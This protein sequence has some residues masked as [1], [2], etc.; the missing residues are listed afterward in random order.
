[1]PKPKPLVDSFMAGLMKDAKNAVD[2]VTKQADIPGTIIPLTPSKKDQDRNNIISG[3]EQEQINIIIEQEQDHE[4]ISEVSDK[5]QV[6]SSSLS[7]KEQEKGSPKE[8][9]PKSPVRP[10]KSITKGAP[11]VSLSK[12]QTQVFLWFKNRGETGVFN[13]PEIE[14]SL[15]MPYITIRKAVAKLESAGV[16]ILTYD[17][18]QKTY[19]YKIDF[20]KPLKL[21]K[22]ISIGS[23]SD[24]DHKGIRSSAPI[25]SSSFIK[26]TTTVDEIKSQIVNN[27]EL[28]Y[29]RQKGLT[30]K[31]IAMWSKQFDM[32]A[33]SIIQ[34]LCYCRFDMV[35]NDREKADSIKDAFNWFYRILER[36]GTYPKPA[37]YKSYQEK[38]IEREKARV[39]E[40][41]RQ[42]EELKKLREEAASA[43]LELEFEQ[44]LQQPDS[45]EYKK[46]FSQIPPFAKRP[47]KI[48]S[49]TF[50]TSMKKAFIDR[51]NE[52]DR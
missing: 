48:G 7:G 12:S 13:K 39:E 36:T 38:A 25:S 16:L 46:C 1:M 14:R 19:E 29:W 23:G 51:K 5:E 17:G 40:L 47:D 27:P 42:A 9:H 37:N 3:S 18:C 26:E 41:K 11:S 52:G 44:M 34:A 30:P 22:N 50:I 24:Q 33:Q 20:K 32:P 31:Q 2:S 6:S 4:S 45:E 49:P 8:Q 21:S 35:D 28:G 15:Q 10:P 43:Q